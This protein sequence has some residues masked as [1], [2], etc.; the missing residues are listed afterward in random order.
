LQGEQSANL[1]I[2][3]S[4]EMLK[5]VKY[6][7][8]TFEF[9]WLGE[10]MEQKWVLSS[11]SPELSAGLFPSVSL[12]LTF[13]QRLTCAVFHWKWISDTKLPIPRIA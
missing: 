3:G 13:D 11:F 7:F 2:H 1:A 12:R 8:P 9:S 10:E 4:S 5:W 6:F